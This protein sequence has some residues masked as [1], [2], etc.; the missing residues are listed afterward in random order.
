MPNEL[1]F[2]VSQYGYLAI[3]L[4]IFLQEVGAPTPLPN[5]FVLIFSGYLAFSG[6]LHLPLI[7]LC[8]L[9]GDLLA[10][11]ILYSVFYLFGNLI[12][13]NK[14]KWLPISQQSINKQAKKIEERGVAGVIIG[15]LSPFIRGYVAV[16]CGLLHIKPQQYGII[17]LFTT[18]LWSCFYIITGYFLGPYWNYV[19]QHIDQFKY[20]LFAIAIVAALSMIARWIIKKRIAHTTTN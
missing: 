1:F 19:I 5:E 3:F 20:L 10:A 2:Y 4:F 12:L 17:V 9:A 13:C 15:R 18:A 7:I 16:I 8:A 14:P 11:A 6:A